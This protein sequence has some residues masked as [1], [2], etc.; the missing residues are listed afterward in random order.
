[1]HLRLAALF[2]FW[3]ATTVTSGHKDLFDV[4]LFAG[5]MSLTIHVL[6]KKK[7]KSP[8]SLILLGL[9]LIVLSVLL[10]GVVSSPTFDFLSG[11]WRSF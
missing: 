9:S 10:F 3:A 4:F 5:A 1:M 8:L 11:L 2:F 6:E 7:I